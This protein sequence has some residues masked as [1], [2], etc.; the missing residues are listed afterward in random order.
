MTVASADIRTYRQERPRERHGFVQIVLPV[1][2]HLRID[3]AGRQDELSTGRGVFIHR[4]APHAQEATDINHS[5]VVDL[6]QNAVPEQTLERFARVPFL[7]IAPD[8]RQL[9][10]YMCG[11][12]KTDGRRDDIA[13]LWAPLLMDSLATEKTGIRLRLRKLSAVVKAEP[14][15]P[16]TIDMLAACASISESRL[17]ALFIEEFGLSPHRWLIGLRMDKVC[18]LLSE[19]SLPIAEIALRAGFSDQTALTRA[20]RNAVGETPAAYRRNRGIH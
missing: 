3:V 17:H 20:L 16:W 18:T 4:D 11:L 5:L 6:D 9:I 7:D 2:G 19:S 10:A 13:G 15:F 1:S 8:T 14:F 12:I